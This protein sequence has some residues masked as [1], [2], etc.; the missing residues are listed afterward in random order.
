MLSLGIRILNSYETLNYTLK[1]IWENMI[2]SLIC[3]VLTKM[4]VCQ[5]VLSVIDDKVV[6]YTFVRIFY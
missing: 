6:R 3:N 5:N 1:S 2:T 4:G